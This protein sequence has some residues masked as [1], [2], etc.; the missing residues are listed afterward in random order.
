MK[1]KGIT[2]LPVVYNK[3]KKKINPT[4]ELMKMRAK[5]KGDIK[6]IEDQRI[7]LNIYTGNNKVHIV[8]VNREM[9][10]GRALDVICLLIGMEN[11]ND[12]V[13]EGLVWI[14]Y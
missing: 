6:L 7:Y 1:I 12:K 9:S 4:V 2:T 8:F 11:T 13:S 5:A 3:Q 14:T 10:I